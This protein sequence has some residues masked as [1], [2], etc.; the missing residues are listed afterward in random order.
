MTAE[1]RGAERADSPGIFA[2]E[3]HGRIVDRLR[4][5]GRLESAEIAAEFQVSGETV[6]RDLIVLEQAGV[7]KRVHGGAVLTAVT[8][9]IPDVHQRETIMRSE[10]AKIAQAAGRY[11]PAQGGLILIDAG[12]TTHAFTEVYTFDAATTV[13]T[14]S[15]VVADEVLRRSESNVHTLGGSVNP[16]TWAESGDWTLHA[17]SG[18]QADVVFL[19]AS[20]VTVAR[21][22]TTSDHTDAMVKRA[23]VKA[24]RRRVLLCDSAKIGVA[25]L[26]H[27]AD[28]GDIDVLITGAKANGSELD[29]LRTLGVEVVVV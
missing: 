18:M 9:V 4:R 24:S 5:K 22:A 26:S 14:P 25:H 15:L 27:F 23:M 16:R 17:L 13:V 1:S 28:P 29:G 19:G 6:R 2:V 3:R 20:G 10:K 21:G 8:G 7:L 11:V 12:T